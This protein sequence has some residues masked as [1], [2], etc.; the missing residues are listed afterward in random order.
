MSFSYKAEKSTFSRKGIHYLT[1]KPKKLSNIGA[2]EKQ[3]YHIASVAMKL[4][5]A[6]AKKFITLK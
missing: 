2:P 3:A 4:K 1:I 5:Q 6:S